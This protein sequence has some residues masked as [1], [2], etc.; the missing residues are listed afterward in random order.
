MQKL[1]NFTAKYSDF[2]QKE[3][4][5]IILVVIIM[6]FL[7]VT[8]FLSYSPA[9]SI[10]I[11]INGLITA[12]ILAATSLGFSLIFG[13][14]KQFKLSIG[15][16][17]LLGAYGMFFM[18]ET[19][20]ISLQKI[21]FSDLDGISFSA[22]IF[23][24]L[25][26]TL[27]ST[28]FIGFYWRKNQLSESTM[29]LFLMLISPYLTIG[30]MLAFSGNTVY[31]FYSGL[32]ISIISVVGWYLEFNK[33]WV[34]ITSVIISL[35]VPL[36][37]LILKFTVIYLLTIIIV[38]VFVAFI[39]ML[40]D[41]YLLDRIR[42]NDVSVLIVTFALAI[43]FQSVVQLTYYP[44][45]GFNFTAFGVASHVY[46]TLIPGSEIFVFPFIG[47]SVKTVKI[48]AFMITVIAL[49]MLFLFLKQSKLGLAIQAVSQDEEAASLA[50]IDIRKVTAIVSGL[51]MGLVGLAAVLT[52]PFAAS[53]LWN[54]SMG[55]SVLIFAIVVVTLG[56]IGS[57]T[58]TLVA[59][60]LLGF[61]S[62]YVGS[63]NLNYSL[64][65][66]ILYQQEPFTL[67]LNSSYTA[68]LPFVVVL[69]VMIIKPTGLFGKEEEL[70]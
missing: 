52:S 53:P 30:G 63:L 27:V 24:P 9:T 66:P 64:Y 33:R 57:I 36:L 20:K 13:V 23:L 31:S 28:F 19:L 45:N 11:F 43:V 41:R 47:G 14:A 40:S 17:Y 37:F 62:S 4:N 26:L 1:T 22:L 55:W 5:T 68:L 50:G 49:I 10:Q 15:G 61:I 56:G 34:S 18:L 8:P 59:S 7:T 51:G 25:I 39:G 70:E 65:I 58:G 46:N 38:V 60:L 35:L 6:V 69:I 42:H 54:P 48:V 2:L 16:Y 3:R 29:Y 67:I 21:S 32:A 44:E 12:S